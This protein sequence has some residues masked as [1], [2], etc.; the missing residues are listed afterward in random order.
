MT[1]LERA[2]LSI[3][4]KLQVREADCLLHGVRTTVDHKFC[5]FKSYSSVLEFMETQALET[6][7]PC[8]EVE[9]V[10]VEGIE[11]KAAYA[12]DMKTV[13]QYLSRKGNTIGGRQTACTASGNRIFGRI[14]MSEFADKLWVSTSVHN[15]ASSIT[16]SDPDYIPFTSII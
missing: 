12:R 9:I 8:K 4:P 2:I 14:E 3:L 11:F 5:G 10:R 1:H 7:Q 6:K 16:F 15:P 13:L